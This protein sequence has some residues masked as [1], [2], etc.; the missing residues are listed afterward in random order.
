MTSF[1]SKSSAAETVDKLRQSYMSGKTRSY[2]WRM[3]Q[4]QRLIDLL[5]E[6]LEAIKEAVHK[7]LKK[8][9]FESVLYEAT[10][11]KTEVVHAMKNL[12]TW[13]KPRAAPKS[14]MQVMDTVYLQKE[15]Y[16]VVLVMGAWN[17]PLQLLLSPFVGALAAG[18][19]ALLK[20]S[21]LAIA[22][23]DLISEL[24]PKYMDKDCVQVML[25][26]IPETTEILKEKFDFICYTGSSPVGKI[27][28]TAA[29]KHLTP[30]LLELGGKSPVYVDAG[31]DLKI[32][33][34]RIVWGKFSNAGQTCVAPDYILC[35]ESEADK[36]VEFFKESIQEMYGENAKDSDSYGK[37]IN[38]RHFKRIAAIL[39]GMPKE[40][41]VCGGN[42][43]SEIDYIE[44]TV[45]KDV[46]L[47]DKVMEDEIFGPL[48]PVIS[49][50]GA[51]HAISIINSKEKPL[52]LYIFSKDDS[53]IETI[54]QETSAGGVLV[55][56]TIM[57]AG[58]TNLPFGGVGNSGMGAYHGINS[59]N[60]FTHEKPVWKRGQNLEAMVA[61]RYP[62]YSEK[63]LSVMK[64][65]MEMS[66]KLSWCNIL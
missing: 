53:T 55:N 59:F 33:A 44:P 6:N 50:K 5:D 23:G 39:E 47:D 15:P 56:D 12:K 27:I 20:P 58:A 18:N 60:T 21:D 45:F 8:H 52:A 29:A 1:S 30:V 22:T 35:H 31:S 42:M 14:F 64:S 17:Y 4:L 43:D 48:L 57:H 25:G 10:V 11:V 32:T 2:E 41:M 37:I 61:G 38:S 46:S 28:M 62:P 54:L 40:K 65:T 26:G 34:N 49:V 9:A 66:E 16:G 36:L 3:Q 13:M 7:D 24:I 63:N 19:C 51:K